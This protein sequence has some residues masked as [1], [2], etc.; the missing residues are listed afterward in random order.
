LIAVDRVP[1]DDTDAT[2]AEEP[3]RD[4]DTVGRAERDRLAR[5]RR[6]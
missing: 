2:V 1:E 3:A 6:R 5:Y 4:L